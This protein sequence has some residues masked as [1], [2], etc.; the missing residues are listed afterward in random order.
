M[1]SSLSLFELSEGDALADRLQ[2]HFEAWLRSAPGRG[3]GTS[4]TLRDESAR[5]YAEMWQAFIAFCAPAGE[6]GRTVRLDPLAD[7][8]RQDLLDFLDHAAS[9]PLR[10]IRTGQDVAALTPR[11]AWRVLQLIDRVINHARE[12]LGR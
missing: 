7:L 1:S 11:Y 2:S 3:P 6:T 12:A 8:G 9:R 5:I 10:K 4:G